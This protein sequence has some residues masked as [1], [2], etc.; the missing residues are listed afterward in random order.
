MTVQNI[1]LDD[2]ESSFIEHVIQEGGY[3]SASEVMRDALRLL[4]EQREE[5]KQRLDRL[6][7]KVR[8]GF[9]QLDNGQ[10]KEYTRETLHEMFDGINA[11]IKARKG[12]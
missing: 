7:E 1:V 3:A 11:R 9:E 5:D 8:V 2:H 6:R 12:L 10:Y 4:E